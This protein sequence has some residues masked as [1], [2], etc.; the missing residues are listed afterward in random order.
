[1][2]KGE[3]KLVFGAGGQDGSYCVEFLLE[4]GHEVIAVVRDSS[5]PRL[6]NLPSGNSNLLILKGDITDHIFL[7]TVIGQYS[8]GTIFNFAAQSHIEMGVRSPLNV[9]NTNA[10]S[11]LVI[12]DLIKKNKNNIRLF[13][14]LTAEILNQ[15]NSQNSNNY[16]FDVRNLYGISKLT[17]YYMCRMYQEQF[18]LHISNG[19]FFNH[20][21]PRRPKSF[22][23]RKISSGVANY[24]ENGSVLELGNLNAIRDWGHARDYVNAAILMTE[25]PE[26]KTL[27]IGS[28]NRYSI[29]EFVNRAFRKVGIDIF[30][31]GHGIDERGLDKSNSQLC[32]RVNKEFYRNYEDSTPK[33]DLSEI[34]RILNWS[35]KVSFDQLV[36]EMV[37]FDLNLL[38]R[39]S[40]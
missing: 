1:M 40:K 24:I 4:Q 32:V 25:L 22:V 26:P 19:I 3:T 5:N 17:S 29:R 10:N 38:R 28:G 9:L 2:S 33:I 11:I 34:K 27:L 14:P 15:T 21:S 18:N 23:S 20:E 13:Q 35:P 16:S 36:E 8:P 30:W 31:D 7:S 37:K 39:K 12:L 6:E